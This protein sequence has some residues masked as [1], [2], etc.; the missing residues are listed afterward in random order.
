MIPH[1]TPFFLPILYP[2]LCW[3]VPTDKK[4]LFLTFDDGP[5]PGPT[6]YVLDTLHN[7]SIKA[8]FFCIGNNIAKH[9]QVFGKIVQDSH[10]V[11]NHTYHHVKGWSTG[12][13]KYAEE[14]KLCEDEIVRSGG[15]PSG[16]FRPPYG[17]ITREQIRILHH[18]K[19]IMWDVLTLDYRK[20][21]SP[22]S[23]LRNSLK[24]IRPGS[25]IVFHDS[26]KAEKNLVFTLPRLIEEGLSDGYTFK[27]LSV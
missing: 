7:Y 17:R 1:R 6:E 19:I 25:I 5:V 21:L 2:A 8:S 24:A 12:S 9:P 10:V 23:C 27:P 11:G 22:D 13:Q 14:V 16:L 4:E 3:R 18:Y 26:Y 15:V 20:S